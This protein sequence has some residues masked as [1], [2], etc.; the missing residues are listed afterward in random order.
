[1]RRRTREV[2]IAP[3]Y[4]SVGETAVSRS[5]R[6]SFGVRRRTAEVIEILRGDV[7]HLLL[8]RGRS[9]TTVAHSI[10]RTSFNLVSR[11][12]HP[13]QRH[14]SYHNRQSRL[15][16][17]IACPSPIV[18]YLTLL[19]SLTVTNP[20]PLQTSSSPSP[21]S[22]SS[23]EERLVSS[24]STRTTKFLA[25]GSR[26]SPASRVRSKRSPVP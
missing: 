2:Y 14:H 21:I 11:L 26:T 22:S 10:S 5:G 3:R 13:G 15:S 18:D 16:S 4:T 19:L 23:D 24:A 25:N 8:Y 6:P 7:Q 9:S 20:S 1:M 12:H 17:T